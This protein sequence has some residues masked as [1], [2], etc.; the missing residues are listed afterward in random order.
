MR[1]SH[2]KVWIMVVPENSEKSL[3]YPWNMYLFSERRKTELCLSYLKL[4]SFINNTSRTWF[5]VSEHTFSWLAFDGCFENQ[6]LATLFSEKYFPL[7]AKLLVYR[8]KYIPCDWQVNLIIFTKLQNLS[9]LVIKVGR[10]VSHS[11]TGIK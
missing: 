3:S 9:N 1:T 2:P 7:Y 8:K 6:I 4:Y 11:L 5:T 10:E